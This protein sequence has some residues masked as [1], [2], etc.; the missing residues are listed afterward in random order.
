MLAFLL[1][2]YFYNQIFDMDWFYSLL[3]I[4]AVLFHVTRPQPDA[5]R[6]LSA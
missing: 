4:N 1:T 3:T 6:R 5:V 2:A